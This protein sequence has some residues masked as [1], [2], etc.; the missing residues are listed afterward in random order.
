M[1]S[2][3]MVAAGVPVLKAVG[4][5]NGVFPTLKVEV[6]ENGVV[7][8]V[9]EFDDPRERYIKTYLEIHNHQP[10]SLAT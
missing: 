6:I 10:V 4:I 3:G 2:A 1:K 5:R 9:I 8:R 7:V